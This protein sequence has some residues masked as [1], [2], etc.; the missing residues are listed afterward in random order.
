MEALFDQTMTRHS[1]KTLSLD[2]EC[3]AV[4]G[5]LMARSPHHPIDKQIAAIA[6]IH[7]LSAVTRNVDDFKSTGVKLR[8]P[9]R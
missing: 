3:A 1:D 8:N 2:R 7:D 5:S 9:F 4:W 6:L